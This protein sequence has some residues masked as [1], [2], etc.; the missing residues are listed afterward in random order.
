MITNL[1]EVR[2]LAISFRADDGW[3]QAV[4]G[5]NLEVRPGETVGLV[6]ESGCGKSVTSLSIMGLL[7][8]TA[9]VSGTIN[10]SGRN[11]T[12][13]E[14]A[15]MR[16]VRG[17]DVSMIF[18]EPM[19]SLNPVLKIR[20]QIAEPLRMHTKLTERQITTRVIELLGH[21]G[22]PNP[23]RVAGEYPHQLS[24]G[25]RQR[26]MIGMAMSCEPK[27]LI[28]DEPTTALDVT[29]QAQILDLLRKLQ[30][31]TGMSILLIT[32]DLGVVAEMCS[33]VSVM[34]A[35]RIVEHCN[36][37]DLYF[38]PQHPY[39]KGLLSSLPAIGQRSRLHPIPGQ[40]PPLWNMP[41]GCR[42]APRCPHAM[43]VCRTTEPNLDTLEG[44]HSVSCWLSDKGGAA[45]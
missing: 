25:M 18:Q 15:Q 35:G 30:A 41:A 1:L 22:I 37:D 43:D 45:S 16:R 44:T 23:A 21:V 9:K 3:V 6:G 11:L 39:T 24:G 13:L 27:L 4:Q 12:G 20:D 28:A 5:V 33:R 2:D 19:T 14:D 7:P 8:K 17:D 31:E 42:F 10:V 36:V 34:Y 38:K 32:H 26:I 29:V 40:V